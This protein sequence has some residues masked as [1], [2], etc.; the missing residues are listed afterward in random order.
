MLAWSGPPDWRAP[1][2][3]LGLQGLSDVLQ[4][5][6]SV[7]TISGDVRVRGSLVVEG[8]ASLQV[9]EGRPRGQGLG[10]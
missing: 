5:S 8:A 1:F 9:R 10:A 6:G 7:L 3:R 2:F 4:L